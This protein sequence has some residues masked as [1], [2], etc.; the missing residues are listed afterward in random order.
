MNTRKEKPH[1]DEDKNILSRRSALKALAGIPV[2]GLFGYE[3]FDKISWDKKKQSRL[4]KELGL[5][6]IHIQQKVPAVSKG[7]LIR[8]GIIGLGNMSHALANPLGFA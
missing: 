1:P 6:D 8:L 5:E 7:D 4:I 2:L 3:L